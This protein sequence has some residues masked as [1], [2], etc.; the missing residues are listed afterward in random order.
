VIATISR[1][2][3]SRANRIIG[4]SCSFYQTTMTSH[5]EGIFYL[6][7]ISSPPSP[8]P[9]PP[10]RTLSPGL[11]NH[12]QQQQQQQPPTQSHRGASQSSRTS[13]P[14][15]SPPPNSPP[16]LPNYM[17]AGIEGSLLSTGGAT[18]SVGVK[19]VTPQAVNPT[20]GVSGLP[21]L[22]GI[23]K[24][25]NQPNASSPLARWQVQPHSDDSDKSSN[26]GSSPGSPERMSGIESGRERS[27]S[28]STVGEGGMASG[29]L[30]GNGMA[31]FSTGLTMTPG[32]TSHYHLLQRK[33]RSGSHSSIKNIDS[34]G[35]SASGSSPSP[36]GSP[37]TSPKRS[38]VQ[39]DSSAAKEMSMFASRT[40]SD[41]LNSVSS[42]FE[43]RGRS[44]SGESVGKEAMSSSFLLRS[45][46]GSGFL[47]DGSTERRRWN[48]DEGSARERGETMPG[49]MAGLGV[50]T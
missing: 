32:S 48:V 47:S 20:L 25:I 41:S 7:G 15:S 40:R 24:S 22:S 36:R 18:T 33:P 34:S 13:S 43:G 44:D 5:S 23:R 37:K 11:I 29:M 10:N 6:E 30:N 1:R 28:T 49:S 21:T 26:G 9:S 39:M 35:T 12:A 42:Q 31:S 27:S 19:S 16:G 4:F 14:R 3:G 45:E 17:A 8:P 2:Y 38:P 46:R 50:K